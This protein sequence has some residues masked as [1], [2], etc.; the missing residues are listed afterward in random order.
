MSAGVE[1]RRSNDGARSRSLNRRVWRREHGAVTN[2]ANA[3]VLRPE[4]ISFEID[5]YVSRA[6]NLRLQCRTTIAGKAIQSDSSECLRDAGRVVAKNAADRTGVEIS[7]RADGR[8]SYDRTL[9]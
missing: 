7:G 6:R 1:D 2:G 9:N 5:R 3:G 4:K 8:L